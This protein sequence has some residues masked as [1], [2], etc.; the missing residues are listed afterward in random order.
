MPRTTHRKRSRAEREA[1]TARI[2][3]AV[4]VAGNLVG[5]VA[6]LVAIGAV[7]WLLTYTAGGGRISAVFPDDIGGTET[8]AFPTLM[9]G[10]SMIGFF[11]GQYAVRGR[12]EVAGGKAS[13]GG[14]FA[15]LL[16]PISVRLHALF[17]ACALTAWVLVMVVPV[18]LDASGALD[19][20]GG[21]SAAIQF[22][23]TV[24]V[25]GVIT[26]LL[27]GMIALSLLKKRTYNDRLARNKSQVTPGSHSQLWWRKF[28]HIWRAELGIA[29]FAGAAFGL[30]PLGVHLQSPLYGFGALAIG[31][32]LMTI[33]VLLALN[34]WRSGL[35]VERV[36]SYT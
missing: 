15:V 14:S 28:S 23:F 22:W 36:E 24:T 30:S 25:Y 34:A 32:V 18:V 2:R 11:L 29:G 27:A 35:P 10:L 16:R 9:V 19:I 3:K 4:A 7:V 20:A 8:I 33:A 31:V 26:G 1:A 21:S 5:A 6:L 13:S 12:W 17:L